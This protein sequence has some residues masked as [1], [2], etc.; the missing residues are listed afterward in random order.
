MKGRI[1]RKT[2]TLM[3]KDKNEDVQESAVCEHCNFPAGE[4]HGCAEG[5]AAGAAAP[6]A[7]AAEEPA[8]DK[9]AGDEGDE[10]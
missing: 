9:G 3:E 4:N 2:T 7:E 6:A 10:E 8:P 5:I 1:A